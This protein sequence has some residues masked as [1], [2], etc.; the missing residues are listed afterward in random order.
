MIYVFMVLNTEIYPPPPWMN[1]NPVHVNN[2]GGW[3]SS[4]KQI[5]STG[6]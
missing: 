3:Y 2:T 5:I 1:Q 4:M 6:K